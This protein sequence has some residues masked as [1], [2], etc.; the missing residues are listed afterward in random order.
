MEM[1][2]TKDCDVAVLGGGPG[3]YAAALRAAQRGARVCLIEAVRV[4]GTCL[5]VGCIPTKA[6]LHASE[7]F[8]NMRHGEK[9]GFSVEKTAVDRAVYMKRVVTTVETVVKGLEALLKA[10]R[11]EVVSGFGRLIARNEI[12]VASTGAAGQSGDFADSVKK[13]VRA[14]NI[15]LAT[16]SRPA[17]PA[18]F[19]W[20]PRV[21]TTD[22]ATLADTMPRSVILVGGGVIGCE[23]ATVYSEL[24]IKVTLVEM[25]E[26]LLSVLDADATRAITRSLKERGVEI[27][28][29]MK[30]ES[31]SA[32]DDGVTAVLA[33]GRT[34]AAEAALIAVGRKPNVEN[35][36]LDAAGVAVQG[37]LIAVD[38]A[39]R[40]NVEGIYAVGDAAVAMQFAHLATRMGLVAAD[41]ATGHPASDDRTVVPVGVYS[42]P[43]IAAVGLGETAARA[44][45]PTLKVS[46]FLY[47]ASGMAQAYG[48]TEGLVKLMG[49]PATGAILGAMVIGQHATDVIQEIA[50]AMRNKLTVEQVAATIH[51]HPTFVEAVG[52]VTES[53]LG[54]PLHA[55]M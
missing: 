30:I 47:R 14:K 13:V 2:E 48:E 15:I 54:L 52:E 16:G 5:N 22:E 25:L 3:G 39:C 51:P 32:G 36:G 43:E 12:E 7:V 46:K 37:G 8:W 11:V 21:F 45:C 10:R 6:M 26:N 27:L 18:M 49:D 35:L 53:F 38:E 1:P 44:V 28:T 41:N 55:L 17:R 34:L 50:C 33:G 9:F 24:G 23:F 19:P 42:H 40:T 20:G 29:E 31:M 4:G